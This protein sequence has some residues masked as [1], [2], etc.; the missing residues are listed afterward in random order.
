MLNFNGISILLVT[1]ILVVSGLLQSPLSKSTVS[2][3][4]PKY[5]TEVILIGCLHGSSSSASD[6]RQVLSSG[7]KTDVIALELCPTRYKDLKKDMKRRK[8]SS[9]EKDN[10]NETDANDGGFLQMVSKTTQSKGIATGIAAL[11]LGGSSIISTKLSGFEAGAEFVAAIEYVES[12]TDADCDVVLA[13]MVVD[14]TLKGV[15]NIPKI[16]ME[17]FKSYISSGFDWNNVYEKNASVLSTAI[18]G[19]KAEGLQQLKLIESLLRNS[20]VITD[21]IR[22]LVPNY[23]LIELVN[24][25]FSFSFGDWAAVAK[26]TP[27]SDVSTQLDWNDWNIILSDSIL[28]LSTSALVLAL[29]Y[30]LFVLPTTSVILTERDIQLSKGIDD[31]CRIASAKDESGGKVVGV[32]GFLH[33]NGVAKTLMTTK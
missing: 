6:V 7:S 25:A 11:I 16:S 24:A 14:E 5:G 31:A 27:I 4:H 8:R 17:M 23:F 18:N 22:L 10:N 19:S 20:Q 30:V 1:N 26:P 29:G 3:H 32:F 2:F 21:I 28:E 12:R 13:D 33:V 15:G 9:I